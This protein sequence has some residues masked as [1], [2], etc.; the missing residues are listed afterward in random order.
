[1]TFFGTLV[2]AVSGLAGCSLILDSKQ[3]QCVV[4]A[5]CAQEDSEGHPVCQQGVCVESGLGPKGCV[6]TA[7]T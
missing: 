2:L 7:P 3:A 6:E 1:M 5:D 4:N